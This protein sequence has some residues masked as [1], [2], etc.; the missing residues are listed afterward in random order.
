[1]EE[2]FK[3]VIWKSF[4]CEGICKAFYLQGRLQNVLSVRA[5]A[6]RPYII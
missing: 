6:K 5:F 1:M 2:F 4:I 3:E